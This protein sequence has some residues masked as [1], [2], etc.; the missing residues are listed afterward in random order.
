MQLDMACIEHMN[1]IDSLVNST[2][3]TAEIPAKRLKMLS[4]YEKYY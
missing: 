1:T 3:D 4:Y 2:S